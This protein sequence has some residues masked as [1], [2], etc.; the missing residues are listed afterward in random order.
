MSSAGA[1]ILGV[2]YLIPVIYLVWSKRYGE[3]ASANPWGAVGLEWE[4][5]SPPPTFN[6]DIPPTVDHEAYE[7]TR[8]DPLA[9]EAPLA[10]LA[11]KAPSPED[12]PPPE[13]P[14]DV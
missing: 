2:G 5:P 1:T 6:F 11:P 8:R 9:P 10:P 7:Y 14:G 4:T 13:S 3:R 12:G